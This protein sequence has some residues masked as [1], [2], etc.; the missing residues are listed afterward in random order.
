MFCFICQEKK[1]ETTATSYIKNSKSTFEYSTY[2]CTK[3]FAEAIQTRV[4]IKPKENK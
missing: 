3:C 4:K 1:I 2:Y